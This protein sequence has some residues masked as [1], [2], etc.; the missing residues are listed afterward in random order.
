[1]SLQ[2]KELVVVR[3]HKHWKRAAFLLAAGIVAVVAPLTL[4]PRFGWFYPVELFSH[5]QVQYLVAAVVCAVVLA[6]LGRWRWCIAAAGCA[7]VAATAVGPFQSS[8]GGGGAAHATPGPEGDETL[9]LLLANVLVGNRQHDRVL[10][11]VAEADADVLVF[12]EV[13]DRWMEALAELEGDYPYTVGMARQDAFGIVVFSRLPLQDAECRSL[14]EAGRPSTVMDLTLDGTPVTIVATHPRHPLSPRSFA[15]RND[16]LGAVGALARDRTRPLILI[17]DLNVTM[18]SPWSRRLCA[19]AQLTNARRGFG[20]MPSWPTF[21]PPI[22]RL[23]IDHCLV[24]DELVV[25]GCRLGPAIGSDHR[26]LIVDVA[27]P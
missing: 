22:M 5:F 19:G 11:L 18:W 27:I 8:L 1:M 10:D 20:V 25:T 6:G 4:V 14:G 23:P 3:S 7:L 17:G 24:S 15:Q 9:R 26:P 12:Q 13:N 16:Q 21:L 2:G